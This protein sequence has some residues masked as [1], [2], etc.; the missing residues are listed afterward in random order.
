V[1]NLT[2]SI[3]TQFVTLFNYAVATIRREYVL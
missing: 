2:L 3:L 1:N